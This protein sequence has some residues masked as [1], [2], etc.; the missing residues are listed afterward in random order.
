MY[1]INQRYILY[2]ISSY[3]LTDLLGKTIQNYKIY[4]IIYE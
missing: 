4:Q 1:I 2:L 3:N